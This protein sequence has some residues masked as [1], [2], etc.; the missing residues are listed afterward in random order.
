MKHL[1]Q[2]ANKDD[3]TK[4][5][6][7]L[8]PLI[9]MVRNLCYH[10]DWVYKEM[11]FGG[12][13]DSDYLESIKT[14]P[15]VIDG[16]LDIDSLRRLIPALGRSVS[17]AFNHYDSAT[18]EFSLGVTDPNYGKDL[19]APSHL[20]AAE[21]VIRNTKERIYDLVYILND[22]YKYAG[23]EEP[24]QMIATHSSSA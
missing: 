17:A 18:E 9:K 14:D 11:N 24:F 22:I 19:E 16:S 13:Y 8:K 20:H 7:I 21:L 1:E 5:G 23:Y 12:T 15:E 6:H 3:A 2:C 10:I 4:L